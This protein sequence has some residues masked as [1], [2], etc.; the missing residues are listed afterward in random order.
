LGQFPDSYNLE[1]IDNFQPKIVSFRTVPI[2]DKDRCEL[3][4]KWLIDQ[5]VVDY[6]NRPTDWINH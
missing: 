4:L 3:K 1:L 6:V 2:T 5:G